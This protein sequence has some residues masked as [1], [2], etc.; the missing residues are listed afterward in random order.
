LH[1]RDRSVDRLLELT[2]QARAE[3]ASPAQC[4]DAETLAAWIGGGLSTAERTRAE[5]HVADCVRC[6]AQV[7]AMA[8]MPSALPASVPRWPRWGVN[9]VW[10]SLA[11][12][13]AVG[14][15]VA[16]WVWV[17]PGAPRLSPEQ[18]SSATTALADRQG[19]A[20][21]SSD[22]NASNG[23]NASKM[24]TARQEREG[25]P[26]STRRPAGAVTQG[27]SR[28]AGNLAFK[29]ESDRAA[30]NDVAASKASNKELAT[31]PPPPA[32]QPASAPASAQAVET[33]ARSNEPLREPSAA[34]AFAGR[35][36]APAAP[37]APAPPPAPAMSIDIVAPDLSTRWRITGGVVVQRSTDAGSTWETQSTGIVSQLTAGSSPAPSICWLVGRAGVVLIT[38]DGRTWRRLAFPEDIDLTTVRATDASTASVTTA[39]G[40]TYGTRDGGMTWAVPPLQESSTG[41]F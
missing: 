28:G 36:G 1:D 17:Q 30:G 6:Q 35:A 26:E 29:R 11:S 20:R 40:R 22:A 25:R 15:A 31:A 3:S 13:A 37:A 21:A 32:P 8:R 24:T 18:P 41:S 16:V 39:A 34:R 10:A 9:R 38:T 33:L 27:A 2:L 14:A 12:L 4:P 5:A 19:E 7:A 23:A